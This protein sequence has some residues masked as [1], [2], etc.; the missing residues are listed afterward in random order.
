MYKVELNAKHKDA[1]ATGGGQGEEGGSQEKPQID[2]H[3]KQKETEYQKVL[4]KHSPQKKALLHSLRH[5][6]GYVKNHKQNDGKAAS[7]TAKSKHLL[8]IDEVDQL[9]PD[10]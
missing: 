3:I 4:K 9:S 2:G 5:E 6:K 8:S 10:N 1:Y 7:S